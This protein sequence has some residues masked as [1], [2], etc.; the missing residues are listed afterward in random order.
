[1]MIILRNAGCIYATWN[2]ALFGT[3]LHSDRHVAFTFLKIIM[4]INSSRHFLM[5]TPLQTRQKSCLKLTVRFKAN[6]IF[7]ISDK[8][9]SRTKDETIEV[10][11]PGPFVRSYKDK[12][13]SF[14]A[15]SGMRMSMAIRPQTVS[16]LASKFDS[17]INNDTTPVSKAN[18]CQ[19]KLRTYDI[20]KII[21]ERLVRNI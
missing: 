17:I 7:V 15:S 11:Q 1:M 21:T 20:S 13:G 2:Y 10:R 12:N 6:L 19:L 3:I 5:H 14:V 16:N 18:N 8:N 9:C 4:I